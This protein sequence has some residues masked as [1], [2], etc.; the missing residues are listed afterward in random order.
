MHIV[1][2]KY[3]D[4]NGNEKTKECYFNFSES[5]LIEMELSINGGISE[6]IRRASQAEDGATIM[7][8]FKEMILKS[9]GI[10][11]IDGDRFEKS[12]K[13]RNDFYQSNAYNSLFIDLVTDADKAANF[14]N[15]L[16]PPDF[17]KNIEEKLA[18][19]KAKKQM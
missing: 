5:E 8:T 13:I 10:K 15:A 9:Y 16:V 1:S 11:S 14:I 4:F 7:A 18:A 2:V 3:K 19:A 17:I 6:M 12:E